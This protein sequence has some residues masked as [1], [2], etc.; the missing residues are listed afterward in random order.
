MIF[1]A[2][3]PKYRNP[4]EL[5]IFQDSILTSPKE[6]VE[7]DHKN[8]KKE[9]LKFSGLMVTVG[10]LNPVALNNLAIRYYLILSSLCFLEKDM[11]GAKVHKEKADS[12][13]HGLIRHF[14]YTEGYSYFLYTVSAYNF[15]WLF[16]GD[17]SF[18]NVSKKTIELCSQTF[19]NLRAPDG[20]V[21]FGDY[22]GEAVSP[23]DYGKGTD[24]QANI[25]VPGFTVIKSTE[26]EKLLGF[27]FFILINHSKDFLDLSWNGH[28]NQEFSS[29]YIWSKGAWVTSFPFYTGWGEKMAKKG[30]LG[31]PVH[32]GKIKGNLDFWF[33]NDKELVVDMV[34]GEIDRV[35]VFNRKETW[36]T[37]EDRNGPGSFFGKGIGFKPENFQV[38]KGVASEKNGGIWLT[39]AERKVKFFV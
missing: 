7:R 30:D 14:L 9:L 29:V 2:L 18:G 4:T 22:R 5:A 27:D 20:K 21:L 8:L 11:K 28:V 26:S 39:G 35:V 13:F 24:F 31:F 25:E 38:L 12:L 19:M 1:H 23:L 17:Y 6:T 15:Y 36:V 33:Q 34:W 37:V 16:Q 32:G 3:L 10:K